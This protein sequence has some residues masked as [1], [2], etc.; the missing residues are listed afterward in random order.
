MHE[1]VL[2]GEP[3]SIGLDAVDRVTDA[4]NPDETEP[5]AVHVGSTDGDRHSSVVDDRE[6]AIEAPAPLVTAL[7]PLVGG[8]DMDVV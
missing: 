3:V 1:A 2:C 5:E 4:V 6:A 8:I 7:G